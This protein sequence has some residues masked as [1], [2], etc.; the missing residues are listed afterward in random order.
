LEKNVNRLSVQMSRIFSQENAQNIQEILHNLDTITELFTKNEE[1][2][3][4][5]LQDLPNLLGAIEY[6]AKRFNTMVSDVV[7]AGTQFT[8]TMK[9]GKSRIDQISHHKD[10]AAVLE[11]GRLDTIAA[12]LEKVTNHKR[13]IPAILIRVNTPPKLRPGE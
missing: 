4:K 8:E 6:S 12:N 1:Y 5:M 2:I 9:A 13:Q 11:L 7:I 10:P 3:T